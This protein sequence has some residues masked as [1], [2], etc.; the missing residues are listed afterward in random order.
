MEIRRQTIPRTEIK[1]GERGGTVF[2]T[3]LFPRMHFKGMTKE[4]KEI[5]SYT[6]YGNVWEVISVAAGLENNS[7]F[8]ESSVIY[9]HEF[10]IRAFSLSNW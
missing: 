3:P 10:L 8:S 1:L 6:D 7:A 4:E 2:C 5:S 9:A